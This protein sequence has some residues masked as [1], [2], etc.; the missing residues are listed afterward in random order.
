MRKGLAII[1]L[2]LAASAQAEVYKCRNSQGAISYRG[3]PCPPDATP[4]PRGGGGLSVVQREAHQ[5]RQEEAAR[6]AAQA[7]RQAARQRE[8]A[9]EREGERRRAEDARRYARERERCLRLFAKRGEI[10]AQLGAGLPA[11][12]FERHKNRLVKVDDQLQDGAC[13]RFKEES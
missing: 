8:A 2:A 13:H 9:R 4:L 7:E 10:H 5:L 1:A 6:Q 3:Q 12:E 11:R